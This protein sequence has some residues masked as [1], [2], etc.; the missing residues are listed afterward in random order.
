MFIAHRSVRINHQLRKWVW[1]S[2]KLCVTGC[3]REEPVPMQVIKGDGST[4]YF[5]M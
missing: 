5:I 2:T 1:T 3:G 4:Y